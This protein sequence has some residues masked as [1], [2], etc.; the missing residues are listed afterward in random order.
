MGAKMKGTVAW[1]FFEGGYW[2]L[3]NLTD[4][5]AEEVDQQPLPFK[6]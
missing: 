1:L 5:A 3:G 6:E 4:V 2:Y